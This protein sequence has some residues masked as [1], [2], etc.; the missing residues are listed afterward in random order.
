MLTCA[1]AAVAQQLHGPQTVLI[2]TAPY[3]DYIAY[4]II[5]WHGVNEA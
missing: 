3:S 2:L 1:C 4:Y 5:A